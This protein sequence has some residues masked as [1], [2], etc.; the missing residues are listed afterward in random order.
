MIHTF[1]VYLP[2]QYSQARAI[3]NDLGVPRWKNYFRGEVHVNGIAGV[4]LGARKKSDEWLLRLRVNPAKLLNGYDGFETISADAAMLERLTVAFRGALEYGV[5][6]HDLPLLPSWLVKR[7]DFAVDV[8][9]P[10]VAD[11]VRL[12]DKGDHPAKYRDQAQGKVGSCYWGCASTRG[13]IYDKALQM[14][15]AGR[16]EALIQRAHNLLRIEV[17][18]KSPKVGYMRNKYEIA[19]RELRHFFNP[20]LAKD[21][22]QRYCQRVFKTGSYRKMAAAQAQMRRLSVSV[23]RQTACLNVLRA[24]AQT[25]SVREGRRQLD[26]SGLT[27]KNQRPPIRLSLSKDAF[28]RNC[29]LLA[30]MDINP[31][32]IPREW[33][34]PSVLSS[35]PEMVQ[36]CFPGST[37]QEELMV[38]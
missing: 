33:E 28:S 21:I 29:R 6:E 13:S 27:I 23:R 12:A 3:L 16:E 36:A 1:E 10:Y 32:T 2:L 14:R 38:I 8:R 20:E 30:Q 7:I 5:G 24:I 19:S 37:I 17:Q 22:L 25:R 31:V 35:F 9:T 18:C 11:Y 15:N 26:Q 34:C 4:H